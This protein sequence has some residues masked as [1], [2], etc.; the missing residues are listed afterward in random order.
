MATNFQP[1]LPSAQ[2]DL[3]S[4]TLK[5]PIDPSSPFGSILQQLGQYLS[6]QQA[7]SEKLPYETFSAPYKELA[8][9]YVE[10]TVRPW[11]EKYTLNPFVEQQAA[12]AAGGGANFMGN[13]ARNY[14]NA[15]N[16]VYSQYFYPQQLQTQNTL[17]SMARDFYNQWAKDYYNSPTAFNNI[18]A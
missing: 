14:T 8:N 4:T 3:P 16:Q 2:I 15:Q 7:Y 11:F 1:T 18:G 12:Q 9:Q 6:P 5:S 10:S 13:A 17:E